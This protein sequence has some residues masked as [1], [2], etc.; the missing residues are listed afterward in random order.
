MIYYLYVKTHNPTGLKYLGRT[1]RNPFKY[2]GS[3]TYWK[4]HIKKHGGNISTTVVGEFETLEDLKTAGISW[5]KRCNVVESME[6]ANL[7]EET[8]EGVP[9]GTPAWNKGKKGLTNNGGPPKGHPCYLTEHSQE[10]K[11]KIRQSHLGKPSKL[12]GRTYEQ[13]YGPEKA[14]QLKKDRSMKMNGNK[15]FGETPWN[16]GHTK[17]TDI[18]LREIGKKVSNTKRRRR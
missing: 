10:T 12:K 4:N 7:T 18:R 8:G 15:N 5:S 1:K 13:I 16:K 14:S 2:K 6:W 9:I 11:E 3:G 17:E